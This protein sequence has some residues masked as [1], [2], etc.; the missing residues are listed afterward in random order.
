MDEQEVGSEASLTQQQLDNPGGDE[1]TS[2]GEQVLNSEQPH[3]QPLN[4]SDSNTPTKSYS[5]EECGKTFSQ[6]LQFRRH[7]CVHTGEKQYP[8]GLCRKSFTTAAALQMHN[9]V[10]TGGR[11][12]NRIKTNQKG[13]QC[14]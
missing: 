4:P 12:T 9:G 1:A 11:P 2:T 7:K 3:Q 5:C 6:S 14:L 8:C 13:E 10:H